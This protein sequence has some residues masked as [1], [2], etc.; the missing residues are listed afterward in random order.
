[1]SGRVL[2]L[3]GTGSLGP[4]LCRALLA[5]GHGVQAFNRGSRPERLPRGVEHLPGDRRKVGG[6]ETLRRASAR[7]V[8][9]TAGWY[10][11]TLPAV[12]GLLAGIDRYVLVSSIAVYP[13]GSPLPVDEDAATGPNPVW[14][15]IGEIKRRCESAC[16]RAA[17]LGLPV[18]ILRPAHLLGED[19]AAS[20]E[21]QLAELL[22]A[23]RAVMVP[24][25]GDA[26]LQFT[27]V[28]DLVETCL[29]LVDDEPDPPSCR[30]NVCAGQIWTIRGWIEHVADQLKI[31]AR[32]KRAP[33]EWCIR[34]RFLYWPGDVVVSAARLRGDLGVVPRS[35]SAY[36]LEEL[37]H[38]KGTPELF[39][40]QPQDRRDFRAA[41]AVRLRRE[42]SCPSG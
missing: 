14:G 12:L 11:E 22:R 38:E 28:A 25:H 5:R 17:G 16:I 34:H 13:G 40:R 30:Y 10:P 7:T 18:T 15:R 29:K 33:F 24:G 36:L 1:M 35:A 20:R 3:G 41:E 27:A 42:S 8:I 21:A 23:G 32:L 26:R 2:V 9:D 31:V 37:G 6:L 39:P 19:P 4:P